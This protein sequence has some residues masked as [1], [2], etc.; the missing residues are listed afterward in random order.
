MIDLNYNIP[1]NV[2]RLR[3]DVGMSS[4]GPNTAFWLNKYDNMAV[5]GIE[6]NPVN[7]QRILDGQFIVNGEIQIIQN[8]NVVKIGNGDILCNYV[9]KGNYFKSFEAAIDNV[10]DICKK[11]FYCTDITNTGCSSLHKP[12]DERLN[13]AKTEFEANVDVISLEKLLDTFPFEQIPLIEFLK[14]DTQSNDL[15]VVKSCGKYLERVCFIFSEYYAH[16]AYEGEKNQNECL[17]E[18]DDF[19]ISNGFKQYYCSGTD[20]AYV[21]TNLI[22]DIIENGII[23]DCMEMQNGLNWI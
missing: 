6:P 8:E 1:K 14:T 4:T 22:S 11:T 13:G 7:Y 23:N 16:S 2:N 15:N 17:R 18:F 5:I 19:M 21:N 3:I 12:I 10:S 9:E 20:V